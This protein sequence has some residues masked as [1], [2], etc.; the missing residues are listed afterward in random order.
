MEIMKAL[1]I[2]PE[3]GFGLEGEFRGQK[4]R[5]E[6]LAASRSVNVYYMVHGEPS[7]F[8]LQRLPKLRECFR[9]LNNI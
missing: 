1:R 8:H 7:V 2:K 4:P 9:S 6:I 5:D 3:K